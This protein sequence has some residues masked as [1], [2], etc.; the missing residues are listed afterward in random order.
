MSA[1]EMDRLFNDYSSNDSLRAS[2]D[3]ASDIGRTAEIARSA[4]YDVTAD[5]VKAHLE[6]LRS[7]AQAELTETQLDAVSGGKFKYI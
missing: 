3:G 5:E 7:G 4:G 2:L 1:T 6:T